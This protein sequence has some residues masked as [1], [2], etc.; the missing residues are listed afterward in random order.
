MRNGPRANVVI[1]MPDNAASR[2]LHQ[3]SHLERGDEARLLD[4]P[5]LKAPR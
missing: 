4:V 3:H 1:E 5:L 2:S